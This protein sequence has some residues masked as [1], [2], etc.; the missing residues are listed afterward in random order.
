MLTGTR[1]S[2]WIA[3]A[4]GL[5]TF[6]L[7]MTLAHKLQAHGDL[8][9]LNRFF[10][11]DCPWYLVN[12]ETGD[13]RF[14]SYAGR[15]LVHPNVANL[16][17]PAVKLVAKALAALHVGSSETL[18]SATSIAVGPASAAARSFFLF[19]ALSVIGF[20][21]GDALLLTALSI[22][23]FSG[24][25]FGALP[26]SFGISAA[27][28][29][30]AFYLFARSIRTMEFKAAPWTIAGT[31]VLGTTITN[32]IPFSFVMAVAN[33]VQNRRLRVTAKQSAKI[34]GGAVVLTA[35]IFVLMTALHGSFRGTGLRHVGQLEEIRPSVK[36]AV[37]LFPTAL[38]NTLLPPAPDRLIGRSGPDDVTGAPD[39][40]EVRVRRFTFRNDL[41]VI[42]ED[43][44]SLSGVVPAD[45]NHLQRYGA[46][47]LC[48]AAFAASLFSFGRLAPEIK[49]LFMV[50]CSQI[51]F[52]WALHA[53]FGYELFL[54]SQHWLI[55]LVIVV[56]AGVAAS[57]RSAWGVRSLVAV[58]TLA[59]AVQS[60]ALFHLILSTH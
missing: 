51:A 5:F 38:R 6:A 58:L 53:F 46:S 14:G 3:L 18:L 34:L 40:N 32:I 42:L 23:S 10:D 33:F 37:S 59:A 43:A 13:Q 56:G 12:F 57:S 17:H 7:E 36:A 16:V 11:A 25:L 21:T 47:I 39:A 27:L 15:S 54:Y 49:L 41:P 48:F 55:P 28:F 19:L 8:Q 22:A 26:E 29:A 52:H 35:S 45:V 4:I 60:G 30:F 31:L 20:A 2:V 50:A 1:A 24:M 9:M 44:R